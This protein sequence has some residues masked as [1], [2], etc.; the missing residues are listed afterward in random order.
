M[1]RSLENQFLWFIVFHCYNQNLT[2]ADGSLVWFGPKLSVAVLITG[3]V[4][5]EADVTLHQKQYRAS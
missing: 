3:T 4:A 2:E 5:T 1:I